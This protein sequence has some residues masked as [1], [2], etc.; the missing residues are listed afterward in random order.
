M[1]VTRGDSSLDI[2]IEDIAPSDAHTYLALSNGKQTKPRSGLARYA[3]DMINDRWLLTGEPIIFNAQGKLDN[4]YTRLHACILA[5][6]LFTTLVVRGTATKTFDVIDTGKSRSL[7]DL[8][9]FRGKEYVST[10]GYVAKRLACIDKGIPVNSSAP[11]TRQEEMATVR[12]Y[13]EIEDY[14][15][16]AQAL[17]KGIPHSL[18]AFTW[19]LF[20]R[21]YPLKTAAFFRAGW[22][23]DGDTVDAKHPAY[24]L[25]NKL[26]NE[27]MSKADRTRF[28][29]VALNAFL[30]GDRPSTLK[31][32]QTSNVLAIGTSGKS[33]T[34]S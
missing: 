22:P 11:V 25:K 34:V 15:R 18:I 30:N 23:Q 10:V 13:P 14:A 12:K 24:R 19:Y 17:G 5:D 31:I 3:E 29:F 28:V 1:R 20:G 16:K 26:T 33:I 32:D 9:R 7:V 21:E 4:G 6:T 2:T 8:L 27:K